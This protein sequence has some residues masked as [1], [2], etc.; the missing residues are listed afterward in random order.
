MAAMADA[1][2]K[3][4][5]RAPIRQARHR[6]IV[7]AHYRVNGKSV[8]TLR[9]APTNAL[10]YN[11]NKGVWQELTSKFDAALLRTVAPR[12][13]PPQRNGRTPGRAPIS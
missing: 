11:T 3:P 9:P 5:F 1:G 10:R 12:V 6:S 2:R 7:D 4:G 13:A 8:G